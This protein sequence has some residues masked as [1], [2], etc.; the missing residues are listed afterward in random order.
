LAK[1]IRVNQLAKELGVESKAILKKLHDEDIPNVPNH[2]SLL[3]IGLA[4]TVREW[5]KSGEIAP[6]EGMAE[7][8]EAPSKAKSARKKKSAG[9]DSGEGSVDVAVQTIP[10]ASAEYSA[11]G[12]TENYGE[13]AEEPGDGGEIV[14]LDT[15]QDYDVEPQ[16]GLQDETQGGALADG[17]DST[18][19]AIEVGSSDNTTDS[20][21][22]DQS[23]DATVGDVSVGGTETSGGLTAGGQT[24]TGSVAAGATPTGA[25]RSS[26]GGAGA[27]KFVAK[28]TVSMRPVSGVPFQPA[29]AKVMGPRVIKDQSPVAVPRPARFGQK[30][31]GPPQKT[32]VKPVVP[33]AKAAAPVVKAPVV[34]APPIAAPSAP[35]VKPVAP[36]APTGIKG[37]GTVAG[38]A[39]LPP[40]PIQRNRLA[41]D[42]SVIRQEQRP[43][44]SLNNP[45]SVKPAAAKPMVR[46]PQL[47]V[48][49]KAQLQGP[50][51]VRIEKPEPVAAPRPRGPVRPN[52]PPAFAAAR[53]GVGRGVKTTTTEDEESDAKKAAA[54]GRLS[55][56]ARR[57]G[58]DGRRGEA[59]ERL[60]EFTEADLIARKDMLN[61]AAAT[62]AG[63]ESHLKKSEA[64]GTHPTAKT[65]VQRGG[66]VEVEEPITPRT[67]SMA[68]GVKT[69]DLLFKLMKKRI[70]ATINQAL[71]TD[72]AM[73]LAL[74]YGLELQVKAET[75]PEERLMLEYDEALAESTELVLRPA[76]VTILGHV[77]HGKTSLL[78]KIRNANVAAGEAGG[79][80]QHIAAWMV[81]VGEGESQKRVTFIDTPGHQAF[82]SMRARGANM[83]DVVVLVVSAAEGVQPQTIESI[84]HAKAA[85]VPIV[86][87]MNKIDRA[88]AN[89][90]MV[91]GQLATHGLNPVEWGGDTEVVRC[92]A[93]TGKGIPE[94]IEILDYQAQLLD[95]KA[96]PTL[97][98]RGT[99]IE[100]RRDEGMGPV[101]TVLVQEG[102]LSVGDYVLCGPG[103]GRV[104]SI[105]NDLGKM[106]PEAGPSMPVI[107]SGLS[108]IPSSGDVL[109][110]VS[111]LD[112]A[113][114][115]AEDRAVRSR[116]KMLAGLQQRTTGANLIQTIKAGDVQTI[117]LII[118][119][120]TQG[121]VETLVKTVTDS[122]TAEVKVRVVHSGVGAITESDVELA[123][124]TKAKPTD[125]RVAIIGFHVVPDEVARGM[126][127]H[128]HV[129]V[130]TYRV[131][132]EIFDDLKKALSG[133]LTPEEREKYHG[134]VEIRQVFKVS[135]VGN[136]AGC[137]VID[138]HIQRGSKIRLIRNGA[139]LV[140]DLT[141]E[142]LKRVKDDAKEVKQGF[143][144]GLKI[145]GYDDIKVTDVL[146]AYIKETFERTL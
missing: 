43:T 41:A 104:R 127:E 59:E 34:T 83:T 63:M 111:D 146:E 91:L 76:V 8:A 33:V 50:R 42:G 81:R 30:V 5:V 18:A 36:V 26:A 52:D 143:E 101:A 13:Q 39:N 3:S 112:E 87:A 93:L 64:R 134:R 92:S 89:P 82:T 44:V 144:C 95:L 98:A 122:N 78:D 138:G 121:S 124:A 7:T 31:P 77:D 29:Q 79:I 107:V 86:V 96:D 27:P 37:P 21:T 125:N 17:G 119:G 109:I 142:S 120:D 28:P 114:A 53:P 108:D 106:I 72:Q 84:N 137:M 74:D 126:A 57:R 141:L 145:A 23:S 115:I 66:V 100:A 49:E 97:P 2:M 6:G 140:E 132:Y 51:V 105:V 117:N 45:S 35:A 1:G 9:G 65:A 68:L 90:D 129:D 12:S 46:A 75:S 113:K 130:K 135:R 73:E 14:A 133:M 19:D 38:G 131:I 102:T 61:A 67:L 110:G 139:V 25:V 55:L 22:G 54:K 16:E 88:D 4:E 40:G 69:N 123:M 99:V 11:E 80:T 62:R 71:T 47:L 48:P 85:E 58:L 60:K 103:Y 116:Q 15:P 24:V 136:I 118:K 10:E 56:S 94:L 20:R 70:M 32:P 128:N